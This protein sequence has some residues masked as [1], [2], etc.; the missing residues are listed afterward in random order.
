VLSKRETVTPPAVVERLLRAA[1]PDVVLVGG[2]AL[3]VWVHRYGLA[4]PDGVAVITAELDFL[5]QS[6]GDRKTVIAFAKALHG[7]THFPNIRSLTALVGQAY[8]DISADEYLNV[9]VIFDVLGIP[10]DAVLARSV[11]VV[12]KQAGT[13]LVMHPLHVLRSRV[14]NLYK[15]PDKQNEKGCMQLAMAIDVARAFVREAAASCATAELASGRSVIQRHVAD[16]ECLALED[17]GRKVAVRHGLHVADAIDPS[18]IPAGPFWIKKWPTLEKLM[19]VPYA[20][21]FADPSAS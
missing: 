13:F 8:L 9:D 17:A 12:S 20:N 2:Q 21:G 14:V 7:A 18:L 3:A 16:I 10:A 15:L 11:A 5:T 6:A 1:G 4:I 19:S